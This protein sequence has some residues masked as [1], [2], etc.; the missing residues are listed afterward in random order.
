MSLKTIPVLVIGGPFRWVRKNHLKITRAQMAQ[1]LGTTENN[2]GRLENGRQI[3]D[4]P[5]ITQIMSAGLMML[6]AMD[7]QVKLNEQTSV[8]P[9]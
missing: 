4:G 7:K 2:I 1:L 6:Y 8:N 3:L 5:I 9:Q